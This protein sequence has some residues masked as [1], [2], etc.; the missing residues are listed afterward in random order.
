[1]LYKNNHFLNDFFMGKMTFVQSR[2]L[3][4]ETR[5]EYGYIKKKP[6]ECCKTSESAFTPKEF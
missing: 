1:M 6:L 2:K 4:I 5:R 3:V